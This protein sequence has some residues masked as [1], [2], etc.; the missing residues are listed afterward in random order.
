MKKRALISIILAAAVIVLVVSHTSS[1]TQSQQHFTQMPPEIAHTL[2]VFK[3]HELQHQRV[4]MTLWSSDDAASRME[5]I[6]LAR[7]AEADP[8]YTHIGVN[9]SDP[10]MIY[11]AYLLRDG[12]S[13]DP[14]QFL[15]TKEQASELFNTYGYTTLTQ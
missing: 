2:G 4:T 13:D 15:A 5:N 11:D 3:L 7:E 6:E 8:N 10:E 14:H 12:L 9:I 1:A